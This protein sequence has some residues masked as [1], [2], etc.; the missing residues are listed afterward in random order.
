MTRGALNDRQC[1][2]RI[3]ALRSRIVADTVEVIADDELDS[4]LRAIGPRE[5]LTRGGLTQRGEHKQVIALAR[6]DGEEVFP[7]YSWR[8][9]RDGGREA[10]MRGVLCQTAIEIQS[11]VG[12]PFDC[13]YCPYSTFICA[14]VDIERFAD[15]VA[16]LTAELSGQ[17]LFKLNNRSDTLGLEPE[18]GLAPLLVERFAELDG[19]YL[20]LYSKGENVKALLGLEHRRKTIACFT[21]TPARIAELL[22][23]GAPPTSAR[24]AAIGQLA[25]AGYPIR[26]RLSP[27]VPLL[28][29][30]NLYNDLI[31]DLIAASEPELITLWALSMID[32][33]NL[34]NIVPLEE[35]DPRILSDA[36]QAAMTMRGKK[37]APFPPTTRASIYRDVAAIIHDHSPRTRV[38]LCLETP[39][40][41]ES[42]GDL[43]VSHSKKRFICNCGPNAT[44]GAVACG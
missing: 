28:D 3:D 4:V 8:E 25:K 24:I 5:E 26:V 42:T 23:P 7:G 44:P 14:R 29:W 17:E 37:G 20:M 36:Q 2:D 6:L 10:R 40:V 27:I 22:E 43:I 13:T 11:V 33:E 12:C 30:H 16:R 41:W 32:V 38:A 21:L 34:D 1:R 9:M 18:L 35:I 39:E 15:R 31:R 19:K